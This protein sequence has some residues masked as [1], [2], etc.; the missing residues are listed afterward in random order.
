MVVSLHV[1]ESMVG[2]MYDMSLSFC[3]LLLRACLV[4]RVSSTIPIS[5]EFFYTYRCLVAQP[6]RA[7]T[8]EFTRQMALSPAQERSLIRASLVGRAGL[9]RATT[10]A[11]LHTHVPRRGLR[12]ATLFPPNLSLSLTRLSLLEPSFASRSTPACVSML[13]SAEA[14]LMPGSTSACS[15]PVSATAATRL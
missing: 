9:A 1:Y 7:G 5:T 10:P 8:A 6:G 3:V 14:Y 15:M 12:P 4:A 11:S 2:L 13:A